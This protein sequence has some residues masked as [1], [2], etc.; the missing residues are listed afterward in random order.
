MT[1]AIAISAAVAAAAAVV[2]AVVCWYDSSDWYRLWVAVVMVA[3]SGSWAA[4]D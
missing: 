1:V 3:G 4:Q 2:V